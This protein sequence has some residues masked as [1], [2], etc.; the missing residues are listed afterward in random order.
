[1]FLDKVRAMEGVATV[2][3]A[4]S[5]YDALARRNLNGRQVSLM[6]TL[7]RSHPLFTASH[8]PDNQSSSKEE[9]LLTSMVFPQIKNAVRTAQA[10]AVNE[11]QKLNMEHIKRVLDVAESFEQDLKGGTGY[12]DAMRSYT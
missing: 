9:T 1:M 10:L 6:L 7:Q 11:R 2:D 5:D 12:A 3:W 4:E 8:Q